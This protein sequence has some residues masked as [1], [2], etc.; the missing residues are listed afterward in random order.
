MPACHRNH[1]ASPCVR[2]AGKR[3]LLFHAPARRNVHQPPPNT[4]RVTGGP[5]GVWSSPTKPPHRTNH[6]IISPT[7]RTRALARPNT[8]LR[9]QPPAPPLRSCAGE[10][11]G[12][13]GDRG[14]A[15]GDGQPPP[16]HLRRRRR[17]LPG[18]VSG[19]LPLSPSDLFIGIY[20]VLLLAV[21]VW[22]L[23]VVLRRSPLRSATETIPFCL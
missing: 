17:R 3:S 6:R 10:K 18:K 15:P 22:L 14:R 12:N 23:S 16:R 9:S 5:S 7:T 13:G 2:V 11:R 8:S 1:V 4:R 19:R 21:V 20:L